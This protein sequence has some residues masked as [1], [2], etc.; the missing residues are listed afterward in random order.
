MLDG[1][2]K[3]TESEVKS[4]LRSKKVKGKKRKKEREYHRQALLKELLEAMI[5]WGPRQA[6]LVLYMRWAKK[7]KNHFH[8]DSLAVLDC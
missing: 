6:V 2:L 1:I 3:E 5:E 8:S 4:T 7:A